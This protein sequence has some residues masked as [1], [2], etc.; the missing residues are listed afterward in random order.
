MNDTHLNDY[1]LELQNVHKSFPGVRALDDVSFR[2]KKG[3]VHGI[4]GENG[5]G[6]STLM[7]ILIGIYRAD[8]GNVI[9]D[10]KKVDF[11]NSASAL[12][13]GLAMVHQELMPVR[14]ITVAQCI[15]LGKE[16]VV[17][18]IR[19]IKD[20]DMVEQSRRLFEE[21]HIN[22]D[23]RKKVGE[24][25]IANIQ[26]MEIV[27]AVS[28]DAK[29]I[30]MDEPTSAITEN[31][32]KNLFSIIKNLKSKGLTILYISHKMDEITAITDE[33]TVLR[34]GKCVATFPTSEKPQEEMINLMVGRELKD[35]FPK[36]ESKIGVIA[37]DVKGLTRRGVFENVSFQVR[38]GEILGFAGLVGAG[39]SEVMRAVFGL[40]PIDSGEI[41]INGEKARIRSPRDAISNKMMFLTEDRKFDGLFLP[42]SVMDNMVIVHL[43]AYKSALT[44]N[45]KKMKED[46]NEQIRLLST[47]T[48]SLDQT[49]V[50]LSGGNQQKV[51]LSKWL[52][53]QPDI[54][55]LDEPTRGIDVGAKVEVYQ[56]IATLASEGKAIIMISSELAEILGLC[57]RVVV[58]R[59]GRKMGE[60]S[61][62]EA[63]QDN[64]MR[65]AF[66]LHENALGEGV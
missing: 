26:L 7:K 57:D 34:D 31:E 42:H 58:M 10:G 53:Q 6:K 41:Y 1:I 49:V 22:I 3:T 9:F 16:P 45:T 54:L 29:L 25:S 23:P 28:Y 19:F 2:V 63:T 61:R 55:M 64:I 32:V 52:I 48:P 38:R 66:G 35:M 65:Y 60:F 59:E 46:C 18:G 5:A 8:A 33:V 56:I 36:N 20:R 37:L 27:K 43:N 4:I 62:E 51:L 15:F 14:G 21:M 24:L 12:A 13:A 44:I 40:D 50:N 17:K 30:I 47:K 11:T 39:R